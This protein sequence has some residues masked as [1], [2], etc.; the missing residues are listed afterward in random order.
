MMKRGG[1]PM[2]VAGEVRPREAQRSFSSTF[3]ST[4]SP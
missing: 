2:L 1:R 3:E 4:D